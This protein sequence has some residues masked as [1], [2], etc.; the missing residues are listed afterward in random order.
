MSR[1]RL[2]QMGVSAAVREL[3]AQ[4][5]DI[6]WR[7]AVELLPQF[8]PLTVKSTVYKE[9]TTPEK[10]PQLPKSMLQRYATKRE[11]YAHG[12]MQAL[13]TRGLV[14]LG[15]DALDTI[16]DKAFLVAEAMEKRGNQ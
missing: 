16:A 6:H 10:L 4:Q 13:I 11:W 9:R 15:T 5:P 14:S 8:N 2:Y 1:S 12:A 7:N 3:L